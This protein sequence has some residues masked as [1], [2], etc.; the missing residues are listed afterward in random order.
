[1]E[2]NVVSPDYRLVTAGKS[3][4]SFTGNFVPGGRVR[5]ILDEPRSL[6]R[7]VLSL[8]AGTA[9][10]TC[11]MIDTIR[12]KY[13]QL[14]AFEASGE[15]FK[16]RH[17]WLHGTDPDTTGFLNIDFA[18]TGLNG[19][20]ND[21][22]TAINM[23]QEDSDGRMVGYIE[24]ELV[25]AQNFAAGGTIDLT[26]RVGPALPKIP[27]TETLAGPGLLK[28]IE[29][30]THT[31]MKPGLVTL[32]NLVDREKN[33]EKRYIRRIFA[34]LNPLHIASFQIRNA[35]QIE[36][37][38]QTLEL[39]ADYA[40]PRREREL[41]ANYFP[42]FDG[43]TRAADVI[44]L[45]AFDRFEMHLQMQNIGGGTPTALPGSMEMVIEYEGAL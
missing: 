24:V 37:E 20:G 44:D 38:F 27:G 40:S 39:L 22:R 13:N 14:T 10:V 33:V 16:A 8:F 25:L 28:R 30:M 41:P 43:G 23:R 11:A 45:H 3:E 36:S 26:T 42:L 17:Q 5:L 9:N 7:A 2:K 4:S 18:E 19:A 12:V 34:K 31:D 15:F 32:K 1:M 6:Q 35:S 29:T 21:L